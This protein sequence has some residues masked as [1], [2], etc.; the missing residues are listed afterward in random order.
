MPPIHSN[1]VGVV[2]SPYSGENSL[3]RKRTSR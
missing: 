2:M 3:G 1:R